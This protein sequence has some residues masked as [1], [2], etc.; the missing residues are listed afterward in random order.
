MAKDPRGLS[1]SR[2]VLRRNRPRSCVWWFLVGSLFGSFGVGLYWM[3][4]APEQVSVPVAAISKAERPAPP[5]PSFQFPTLLKDTVVDT[6]AGKPLPP[7]APRPEPPPREPVVQQPPRDPVVQ[8][9]APRDPAPVAAQT[10]RQAPQ[11]SYLLQVGSF[12]RAAD[13]E[14]MKA[15]LALLGISTRVES[16]TINTGE[17]YHR[18]RTG[19]F[20][21]KQAME[22][23]RKA[24]KR[25]G[26]DS[27]AIKVQ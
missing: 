12:K 15:E 13:A 27:M 7:P 4:E 18:V 16:V 24:L 25:H 1:G 19:P 23:A 2:G 8:Q 10:P 20:D 17:V 22:E 26:Q 14:R 9:P 11:G 5:Q 21:G 3:L 6:S